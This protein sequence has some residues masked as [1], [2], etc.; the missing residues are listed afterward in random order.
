MLL[1]SKL[2][3]HLKESISKCA[4]AMVDVGNDAEIPIE[5]RAPKKFTL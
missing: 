3:S 2:T 5:V 1:T 4:L